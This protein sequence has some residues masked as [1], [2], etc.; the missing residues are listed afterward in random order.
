M[1]ITRR[2]IQKLNCPRHHK[3]SGS[4]GVYD[5]YK[6]IRKNKWLDISRPLTEHEF[7]SIIRLMNNKIAQRLAKGDPFVLPCKMGMIE[8]RKRPLCTLIDNKGK[9]RTNKSIDWDSTV[10]LWCKDPEEYKNKRL[11][12]FDSKERFRFRYSKSKAIYNNKCYFRIKMNK[13]LRRELANN[14]N[15]G[16]VDAYLLYE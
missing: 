14:I 4:L 3:I 5:A 10:D 2:R 12:Y 13:E 15:K 16:S 7:Y 8:L 6:W 1:E 9:V 11:I